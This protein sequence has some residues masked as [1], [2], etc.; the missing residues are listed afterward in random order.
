MTKEK[1]MNI[2]L[3][4]FSIGDSYNYTL[5]RIKEGFSYGTVSIEDFEEFD[6]EVVEDI[7]DYILA[8][9]EEK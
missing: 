3:E 9:L 5:T 7:V 4:Y 6:E 8:N 2:L 1:L